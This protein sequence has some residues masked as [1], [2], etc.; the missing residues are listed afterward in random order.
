LKTFRQDYQL[1][2][3]E[4][5]YLRANYEEKLRALEPCLSKLTNEIYNYDDF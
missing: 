5:V 4:K 3:N 2:H 1:E